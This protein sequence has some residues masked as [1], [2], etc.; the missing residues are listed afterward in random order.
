MQDE[1]GTSVERRR[2]YRL[3][4]P[5]DCRPTVV[6][7]G[8]YLPLAELSPRGVRVVVDEPRWRP[9]DLCDVELRLASQPVLRVPDAVVLRLEC[10]ELVIWLTVPID[11][12][13]VLREQRRLIR[14]ARRMTDPGALN[15]LRTW[16][17]VER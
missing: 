13:V 9:G 15:A 7:D 17:P 4:Y 11:P 10:A 2:F 14:R 8:D 5:D 3:R 16:P 1:G 6:I 12:A